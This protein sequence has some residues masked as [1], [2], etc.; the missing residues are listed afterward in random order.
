MDF[1]TDSSS[2]DSVCRQV[3]ANPLQ[4]SACKGALHSVQHFRTNGFIHGVQPGIGTGRYE[5]LPV[6][7][8]VYQRL[9][10][11]RMPQ[12]QTL[13]FS[14]LNTLKIGGWEVSRVYVCMILV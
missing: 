3:K 12:D 14:L 5:G 13:I 6:Q 8:P 1:Y 4:K 10:S 7:T 2:A 11:A 9:L